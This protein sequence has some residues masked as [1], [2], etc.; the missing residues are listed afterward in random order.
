MNIVVIEGAELGQL[1]DLMRD[2]G[3]DEGRSRIRKLRVSA[4]RDGFKLKINEATWTVPCGTP[5]ESPPTMPPPAAIC[6]CCQQQLS[7]SGYLQRW[8]SSDGHADCGKSPT[9][10][11][12][13][14]LSY[15]DVA[16]FN[17]EGRQDDD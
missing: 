13:P 1:L 7:W 6:G 10:Y 11:H 5:W 9:N 8:A 15:G 12:R 14:R 2:M 3:S 16:A 4:D 17:A